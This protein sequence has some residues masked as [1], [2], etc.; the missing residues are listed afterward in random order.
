MTE[1]IDINETTAEDVLD[2]PKT[3]EETEKVDT[4]PV[5]SENTDEIPNTGIDYAEI[6]AND[7]NE[8]SKELFSGEEIKI[9]DLKNPTRYGALRDLGL[10]PKEAFLASG[11]R[12]E[13]RDNRSHLHSSVPRSIAAAFSE[14]PRAHLDAARELFSEL[15]DGEIK[16]LYKKVTQ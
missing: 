9:T 7:M 16:A 13:R 1:A 10:T 3:A 4:P 12:I 5:V 6:V 2:A 8:L 15:N 14:I 11:G